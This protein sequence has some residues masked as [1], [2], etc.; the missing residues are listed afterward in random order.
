M[1][2]LFKNGNRVGQA[3][4]AIAV[5]LGAFGIGLSAI[6]C[7]VQYRLEVVAPPNQLA[8]INF[9][10]PGLAE[11]RGVVSNNY[12]APFGFV[13]KTWAYIDPSI[14]ATANPTGKERPIPYLWFADRRN[15]AEYFRPRVFV[16]FQG[17][18]T[19]SDLIYF[20]GAYADHRGGC[21]TVPLVRRAFSSIEEGGA[22]Q[23]KAAAHPYGERE[24]PLVPIAQDEVYGRWAIVQLNW[25]P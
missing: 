10:Q 12:A 16:C 9:L 19:L 21:P 22:V 11:G 13:S 14:G 23:P 20:T 18:S 2:V 24:L 3:R 7:L 25:K 5:V 8:F 4:R 15:N 1:W 6:W 17:L